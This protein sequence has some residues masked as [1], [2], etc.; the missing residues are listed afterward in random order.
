[1][2][3]C[4]PKQQSPTE[5]SLQ[6]GAYSAQGRR[7]GDNIYLSCAAVEAA[8]EQLVR[9]LRMLRPLARWRCVPCATG[10]AARRGRADVADALRTAGGGVG[11]GIGLSTIAWAAPYCIALRADSPDSAQR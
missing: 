1:M 11:V 3:S 6:R 8:P 10:I 7:Y 2:N 5:G 4:S 9:H